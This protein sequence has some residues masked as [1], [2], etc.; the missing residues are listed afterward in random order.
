M[1]PTIDI[2]E[3]GVEA[4]AVTVSNPIAPSFIVEADPSLDSPAIQGLIVLAVACGL[5][6]IWSVVLRTWR[7]RGVERLQM[8]LF[9]FVILLIPLHI[10]IGGI[11]PRFHDSALGDVTFTHH[12][13]ADP[14][15][16]WRGDSC[17]IGCTT[18]TGSSG[19]RR[20]TDW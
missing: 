1:A 15:G 14:P 4:N 16:V 18:L 11:S 9:A 5:A 7:S 17:G 3:V 10:L 12:H 2:G 19:A 13:D 8:R 20:H 6:S